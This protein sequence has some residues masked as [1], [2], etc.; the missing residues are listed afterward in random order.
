MRVFP[1]PL[2][3]WHHEYSGKYVGLEP[4]YFQILSLI[5]SWVAFQDT[6][7]PLLCSAAVDYLFEAFAKLTNST[8]L[9]SFPNP[10]SKIKHL[11]KYNFK[12]RKG[13]QKT[14]KYPISSR[15]FFYF[16]RQASLSMAHYN[17]TC[18]SKEGLRD[19][20]SV[21]QLYKNILFHGNCLE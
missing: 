2:K 16:K 20:E 6:P 10:L 14:E 1:K 9:I 4:K 8:W 13:G 19:K 18:H 11:E 17:I 21:V 5:L 7:Q 15:L 3:S 12:E